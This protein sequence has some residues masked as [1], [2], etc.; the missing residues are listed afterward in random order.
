MLT[1]KCSS[2][3]V[4]PIAETDESIKRRLEPISFATTCLSLVLRAR[5]RGQCPDPP[6]F[7]RARHER[8][9]ESDALLRV[10]EGVVRRASRPDLL[11]DKGFSSMRA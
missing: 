5:H 10:F 8:F 9:R 1:Q 11:A 4:L 7:C 6:V 2:N 3:Q